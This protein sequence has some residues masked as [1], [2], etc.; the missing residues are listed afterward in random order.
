M[1]NIFD[2]TTLQGLKLWIQQLRTLD[3]IIQ[4]EGSEAYIA[5]IFQIFNKIQ[6]QRAQ[7]EQYFSSS[8]QSASATSPSISNRDIGSQ[9]SFQ[10]SLS[11]SSRT[12]PVVPQQVPPH[13]NNV[14]STVTG[15][16]QTGN[17]PVYQPAD[18]GIHYMPHQQWS[19][20]HTSAY[21]Q[22][23]PQLH[24]Q[25][26][27]SSF[28]HY[29]QTQ[30]PPQSFIHLQTGQWM[31][32]PPAPLYSQYTG[33]QQLPQPMM[34][35]SQT[36]PTTVV[37]KEVELMSSNGVPKRS[38]ASGKSAKKR[39][40]CGNEHSLVVC[41]KENLPSGNKPSLNTS[42]SKNKEKKQEKPKL[43]ESPTKREDKQENQFVATSTYTDETPHISCNLTS[44]VVEEN[45]ETEKI[46][47]PKS[48]KHG[49]SSEPEQL[50]NSTSKNVLIIDDDNSA[51]FI[52]KDKTSEDMDE[53]PKPSSFTDDDQLTFPNKLEEK[54]ERNK[55]RTI[56]SVRFGEVDSCK[57]RCNVAT[58]DADWAPGK[59]AVTD[60]L[61]SSFETFVVG[62]YN[63][64]K[65]KRNH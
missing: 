59:P 1:T 51:G 2:Q 8:T 20:Q 4:D 56:E 63:K 45:P 29:G 52:Q 27:Q 14:Q 35:P 48:T 61:G 24:Y 11:V 30:A 62:F 50:D 57:R 47:S 16:Q 44:K 18:V 40:Q 39:R 22:S 21:Q 37:Q 42:D 7:M 12:S 15:P 58:F 64:P 33:G 54:H 23:R 9:L 13:W 53:N 36:F 41:N 46:T 5:K 38:I 19:G 55:K 32:P 43:K 34:L 10:S 3:A 17:F 65:K 31:Q 6:T 60:V 28:Y 25:Q 26:Q 49:Q